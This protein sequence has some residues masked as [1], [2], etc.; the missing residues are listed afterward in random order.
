[1]DKIEMTKTVALIA[2]SA[3]VSSVISNVRDTV[4]PEDSN[5]LEKAITWIGFAVLGAMILDKAYDYMEPKIDEAVDY[6]NEHIIGRI[7]NELK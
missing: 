1:M 6:I 5:K 3:G 4:E 7:K 2:V